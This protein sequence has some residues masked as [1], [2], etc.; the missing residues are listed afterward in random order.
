[1]LNNQDFAQSKP[2]S[3]AKRRLELV[4]GGNQ[5]AE[6]ASQ[7]SDLHRAIKLLQGTILK[8]DGAYAPSTIRAYRADFIDFIRFCHDRNANALPAQPHLVVQYIEPLSI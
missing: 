3:P 4:S 7:S 1:M 8:I 5:S 6:N 2:K